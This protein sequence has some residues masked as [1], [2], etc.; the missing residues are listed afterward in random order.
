MD[1][2]FVHRKGKKHFL[3][4]D[5]FPILA[6]GMQSHTITCALLCGDIPSHHFK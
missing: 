2:N 1:A 4:Q 6:T 3:V 5:L